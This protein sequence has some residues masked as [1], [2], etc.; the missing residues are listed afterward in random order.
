MSDFLF[1]EV[2][3]QEK[4]KIRKEAKAIMDNFSKKLSKVDGKISESFIERDVSERQDGNG[5]E[6]DE[7]FRRRVLENAPNKNSDFIIGEKKSW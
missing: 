6:C 5:S 4:E 1:H 7:D 2:S 3:E